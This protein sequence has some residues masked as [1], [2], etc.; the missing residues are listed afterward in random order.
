MQNKT[1]RSTHSWYP[2]DSP[3]GRVVMFLSSTRYPGLWQHRSTGA[4]TSTLPTQAA[5]TVH[6]YQPWLSCHSHHSCEISSLESLAGTPFITLGYSHC[7]LAVQKLKQCHPR[8]IL[9]KLPFALTV[10]LEY[11]M[12]R[13]PAVD[14]N[15]DEI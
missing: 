6:M 4:Q 15:V 13:N 2:W 1:H 3:L 14:G 9:H 12:Q 5:D 7:P 10:I 11:L 8:H